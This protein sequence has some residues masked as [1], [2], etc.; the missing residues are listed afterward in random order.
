MGR[1]VMIDRGSLSEVQTTYAGSMPV[2]HE[3]AVRAV[4]TDCQ[5]VRQLPA[6]IQ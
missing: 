2:L 5:A 6:S 3:R 1:P 4:Q